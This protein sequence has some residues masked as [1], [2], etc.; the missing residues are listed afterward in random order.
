M[1]PKKKKIFVFRNTHDPFL[2]RERT[3]TFM[4]WQA[5]AVNMQGHP[6][7]KVH[8]CVDPGEQA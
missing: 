5:T 7:G 6:T 8:A 1:M 2:W 4:L 3:L